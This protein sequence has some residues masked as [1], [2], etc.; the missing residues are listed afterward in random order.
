[1]WLMGHRNP[2]HQQRMGAYALE[3]N[4][5]KWKTL[6][7]QAI[8]TGTKGR[9]GFKQESN[10]IPLF[11]FVGHEILSSRLQGAQLIGRMVLA[12]I[13]Q[14]LPTRT[15]LLALLRYQADQFF[16]NRLSQ[17]LSDWFFF[18]PIMSL[19]PIQMLNL[20]VLR[21]MG[22]RTVLFLKCDMKN[23]VFPFCFS[24]T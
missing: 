18:V 21:V 20:V 17:R 5:M 24:R 6:T 4:E 2:S 9:Y 19:F 13:C 8:T 12:S 22:V 7:V 1:M 15:R 3:V 11:Q 10:P 16:N 14:P 23:F